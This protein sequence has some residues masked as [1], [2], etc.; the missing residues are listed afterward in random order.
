MAVN[1]CG[2]V[3]LETSSVPEPAGSASST[4]ASWWLVR[5]DR[6]MQA[7]PEFRGWWSHHDIGVGEV[8]RK[9][10]HHPRAGL[11]V[12]Q[13]TML[14]LANDPNPKLFLYTPLAQTNTAEKLAWL[15]KTRSA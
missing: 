1:V 4:G 10:L 6:L 13:P 7:S 14:V 3:E 9:E 8:S 2:L 11:L 5:R 15:V 12:L